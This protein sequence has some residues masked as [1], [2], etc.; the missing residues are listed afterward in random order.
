MSNIN[1]KRCYKKITGKIEENILIAN[2]KCPDIRI[3]LKFKLNFL[4]LIEIVSGHCTYRIHFTTTLSWINKE[5]KIVLYYFEPPS[6]SVLKSSARTFCWLHFPFPSLTIYVLYPAISRIIK[7]NKTI[8]Q[9]V[10]TLLLDLFFQCAARLPYSTTF[11]TFMPFV[12]NKHICWLFFWCIDKIG[13]IFQFEIQIMKR[14]LFLDSH[15][16]RK[17]RIKK[18]RINSLMRDKKERF[19]IFFFFLLLNKFQFCNMCFGICEYNRRGLNNNNN[20]GFVSSEIWNSWDRQFF[21]HF[22]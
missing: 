11:L 6:R 13:A 3:F 9:F 5:L 15:P 17:S 12:L 21:D 2:L 4:Y 18:N 10:S 20:G 8:I 22:L 16:L 7:F 19:S 1:L 14:A